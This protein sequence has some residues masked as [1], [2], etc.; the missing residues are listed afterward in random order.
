M[1]RVNNLCLISILIII[2]LLPGSPLRYNIYYTN[3]IINIISLIYIAKNIDKKQNLYINKIDVIILLLSL[4]TFI[5]LIFNTYLSLIDTVEYILRYISAFNIYFI[6]KLYMKN[7]NN[8]INIILKSFIYMS[9]VLIIIGIDMMSSNYFHSLY[10]F[11]R[12][13]ILIKESPERMISLFKYPNV[14]CVY[15]S[16]I[17][18]LTLGCYLKE[19]NK[20]KKGIYLIFIFIQFFGIIMSYSRLCWS[21]TIVLLIIYF[22]ILKNERKTLIK[23]IALS[24]TSAFT[25][26]CIYTHFLNK[27]DTIILCLFLLIVAIIQFTI[28][29][30]INK[31]RLKELNKKMLVLIVLVILLVSSIIISMIYLLHPNY[32]VLFNNNNFKRNYRRQNI[33]V[34]ENETYKF[35][36]DIEAISNIK[37]NF[38][39]AI[40]QLDE[41]EKEI[42]VDKLVFDNYKGIKDIDIK[43]LENT[44]SITLSITCEEPNTNSKLIIYSAKYNEKNVKIYY[45]LIP[46][47]FVNRIGK[48]KIKTASTNLRI[49]YMKKA[50]SII[51]TS[52]IFGLGGNAWN[53]SNMDG[54][55]I[56]TVAEHSYPLQLFLQ[57]GVLSF[58]LYLILIIMILIIS[59]KIIKNKENDITLISIIFALFMLIL[60][61]IADFDFNFQLILLEMFIFIAIINILIKNQKQINIKNIYK[62]IYLSFLIVLLY[63]NIGETITLQMNYNKDKS[64]TEFE[65]LKE[66]NIKTVLSP[67]Y[68][69]NYEEKMNCLSRIKNKG[70]E[71]KQDN[72]ESEIIKCA[73]FITDIEKDKSSNIYCIIILNTIDMMN[74]KNQEEILKKVQ[75][76]WENEVGAN[77]KMIYNAMKNRLKLVL[78]NDITEQFIDNL[79]II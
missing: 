35:K 67:Y 76:I 53:H 55:K 9:I 27:T 5:P 75:N 37:D 63:I 54:I 29:I 1:K 33:V 48:Y 16:S 23:A 19:Q 11:L 42:K 57:N 13:P 65:Q 43:T 64:K 26:Y 59:I 17:L 49:T 69:K 38:T 62:Y 70:L 56:K 73:R 41:D 10:D 44:K 51:K 21:I 78:D 28:Y 30:N 66:T 61:S 52:P 47:S 18:F 14:F 7:N 71:Y 36:F 12:V 68:Y 3:I 77:D 15:I 2:N 6:V 74:E 79:K 22:L 46:I 50:I 72:I 34:G 45:K 31:L 25:Y 8:N 60:H 24:F 40:K 58:S 32:L 4:S 39:I 20:L